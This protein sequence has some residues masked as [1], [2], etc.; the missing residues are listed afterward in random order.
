MPVCARCS[1]L[2]LSAAVG[3]LRRLGSRVCERASTRAL[4]IAA[5]PTAITFVLEVVGVPFS[6]VARAIAALPL[7]AVVGWLFVRMLRYDSRLDAHEN[8]GQLNPRAS[9]RNLVRSCCSARCRGSCRA[10]GTCGPGDVQKG[11]IFLLA[12]SR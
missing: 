4:M 1:G 10:P 6:N 7:G 9:Q 8:P 11:V 5:L 2:Y 12:Q 3:T